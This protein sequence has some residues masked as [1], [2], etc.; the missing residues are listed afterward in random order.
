M[1]ENF[2]LLHPTSKSPAQMHDLSSRCI[3]WMHNFS[4]EVS[5]LSLR[6]NSSIKKGIKVLPA[7][8]SN[9]SNLIHNTKQQTHIFWLSSSAQDQVILLQQLQRK[10][11]LIPVSSKIQ[12]VILRNLL[13]SHI[14]PCGDGGISRQ[15]YGCLQI[16]AHLPAIPSNWS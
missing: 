5:H 13:F 11:Q 2:S 3:T 7:V 1:K 6:P 16:Y 12:S 15:L 8:P 9:L 14:R 4:S 10:I